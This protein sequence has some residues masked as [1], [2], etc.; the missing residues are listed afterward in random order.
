MTAKSLWFEL[1][2]KPENALRYFNFRKEGDS[3]AADVADDY[4]S[5]DA[6]PITTAG[7]KLLKKAVEV[8]AQQIHT[9]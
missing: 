4:I 9:E 8:S 7:E 3:I 6:N 5:L 1:N 2:K